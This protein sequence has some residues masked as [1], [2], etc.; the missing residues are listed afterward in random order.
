MPAPPTATTDW[1]PT[2]RSVHASSIEHA[3]HIS[4][5][6]AGRIAASEATYTVPTLAVIHLIMEHGAA[7]GMPPE[8]VAKVQGLREQMLASIE[9]CRAAG[10]KIGLGTDI[11][12]TD[13]HHMQANELR[14]RAE[15]DR[16]IDV[17]RS[18]TSINAEIVQRK[19][20]LGWSPP[21]PRPT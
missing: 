21:A 17:L 7:A 10:V 15:V 4:D 16:P 8:S 18:A 20:E 3:T 2:A 11:F 1:T 12:G 5:E 19:G 6:T 9:S 14:Y 13:F